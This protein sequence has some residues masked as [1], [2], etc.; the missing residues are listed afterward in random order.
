[1][2]AGCDSPTQSTST[3]NKHKIEQSMSNQ[4]ENRSLPISFAPPGINTLTDI[5]IA[6]DSYGNESVVIQGVISGGSQGGWGGENDEYE[7]HCFDFVAWRREDGPVVDQELTILRAVP[8]EF[9][10][11]DDFPE[12]SVQKISVLLSSDE[13]RAVFEKAIASN[14]QDEELSNISDNLQNPVSIETKRFGTLNLDRRMGQFVGETKWNK[15]SIRIAFDSENEK[16][17]SSALSTAET[18]WGSRAEWNKRIEAIAV[19]KLLELKNSTWL[20]DGE[21]EFSA[22]QFVAAMSLTSVSIDSEGG[23]T[24]WYD[25]GELFWGHLIK[26][27]G[28]QEEGPTDA[29]IQG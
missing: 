15:K 19:S 4:D 10:Y 1:M 29:S 25:D 22:K 3:S 12:Y 13:S 16:I 27:Q 14:G 2:I 26:V 21:S 5:D 17:N 20:K 23:F 6:N 18:I 7:V 9:D 28:N 24:F 11:W 8:P